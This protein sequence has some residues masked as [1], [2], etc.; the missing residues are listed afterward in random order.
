MTLTS[1]KQEDLSRGAWVCCHAHRH[2]TD[3]YLCKSQSDVLRLELEIIEE[4]WEGDEPFEDSR[5]ARDAYWEDRMLRNEFWEAVFR[6][7]V[8]WE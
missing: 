7:W 6:E 4:N 3:Y 2:G 1:S 8:S 5:E